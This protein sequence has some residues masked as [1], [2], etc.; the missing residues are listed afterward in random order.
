MRGGQTRRNVWMRHANRSHNDAQA[1]WYSIFHLEKDWTG[2]F[3]AHRLHFQGHCA[4]VVEHCIKQQ[5]VHSGVRLDEQRQDYERPFGP[6]IDQCFHFK[7]QR[8]N[9]GYAPA[10][11]KVGWWFSM[12]LYLIYSQLYALSL[13]LWNSTEINKNWIIPLH[14]F[15]EI[16]QTSIRYHVAL[17]EML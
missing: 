16:K 7:D 11:E 17:K 12:I 9:A 13:L 8:P 15:V 5:A 4:W 14:S 6:Q 10:G 1:F 2:C 3:Q